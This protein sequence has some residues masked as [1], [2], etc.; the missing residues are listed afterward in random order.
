MDL[1]LL[2]RYWETVMI[3][4]A[5]WFSVD[6]YD[7]LILD[8]CWATRSKRFIVPGTE[9]LIDS[10]RN[11]WWHVKMSLIGMVLG[12]PVALFAGLATLVLR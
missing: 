9:D 10:Y 4:Y 3:S 6:W 5:L 11:K 2:Y 12:V 1:H 7:C 8:F